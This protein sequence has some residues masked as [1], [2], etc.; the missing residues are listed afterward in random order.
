MLVWK[1]KY[2]CI[3]ACI[4]TWPRNF[5]SS[6]TYL[7]PRQDVRKLEAQGPVTQLHG[8]RPRLLLEPHDRSVVEA[9]HA[10]V[11]A[12]ILGVENLDVLFGNDQS[13]LE[14]AGDSA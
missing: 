6:V 11:I 13:P 8:M 5:S 12:D 2:T 9:R 3:H 4:C 10:T 1:Y 7:G 14:F